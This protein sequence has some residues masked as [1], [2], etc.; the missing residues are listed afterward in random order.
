MNKILFCR[1]PNRAKQIKGDRYICADITNDG[2]KSISA[3]KIDAYK[4]F[5]KIR[6]LLQS[7]IVNEF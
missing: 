7:F 4:L 2:I 5:Q 3:P 1:H 6:K